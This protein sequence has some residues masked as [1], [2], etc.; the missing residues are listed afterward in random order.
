VVIESELKVSKEI[1]SDVI[2]LG[3]TIEEAIWEKF[4]TF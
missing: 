2:N 1:S 4:Y 3:F